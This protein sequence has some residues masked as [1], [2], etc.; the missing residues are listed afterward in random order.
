MVEGVA[1]SDADAAAE[2]TVVLVLVEVGAFAESGSAKFTDL[3]DDA[4]CFF[5]L[6]PLKLRPFVIEAGVDLLVAAQA[7][8]DRSIL[9]R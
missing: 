3:T 4:G 2:T 6:V 5:G 1:S 7:R 9:C 8:C